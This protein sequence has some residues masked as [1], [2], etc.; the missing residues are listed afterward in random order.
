[1]TAACVTEKEMQKQYLR[2]IL[3]PITEKFVFNLIW[4]LFLKRMG[5]FANVHLFYDSIF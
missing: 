2:E 4:I 5:T 3:M 1:M